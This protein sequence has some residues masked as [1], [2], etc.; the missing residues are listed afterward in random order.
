MKWSNANILIII[1][2]SL[3]TKEGRQRCAA[4]E[5]E[6]EDAKTCEKKKRK[7][8]QDQEEIVWFMCI[9]IL[10]NV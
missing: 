7:S 6:R 10:V 1:I 8:N 3:G 2:S 9:F 5:E 4:R